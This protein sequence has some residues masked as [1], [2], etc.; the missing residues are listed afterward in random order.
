MRILFCLSILII[1]AIAFRQ[2][3]NGCGVNER[4]VLRQPGDNWQED[5]NRCRCLAAGVPGCTKK[6]CGGFPSLFEPESS[7]C[8]DS[9]GSPRQEGEQWEESGDTCSCGQGEVVCTALV[10]ATGVKRDKADLPASDGVNFPD[11]NQQSGDALGIGQKSPEAPALFSPSPRAVRQTVQ[12]RQ[13]GVT[14]CQAVNINLEYLQTLKPGHSVRFSQE[15]QLSMKLR[16]VPSGSLSSTLHYSFSLPAGGEGTVTVKPN[17]G[18]G[19][20]P[21]VF[22]SIRPGTGS[23]IFFVEACGQGCNVLYQRNRDFFNQFQD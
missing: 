17:K 1:G 13:A 6:F 15:H 5:C 16:R 10:T 8:L 4:G 22:A 21:S 7:P 14:T 19:T 9:Q 12:C 23:A 11:R 3:E 2:A 18:S 20:A